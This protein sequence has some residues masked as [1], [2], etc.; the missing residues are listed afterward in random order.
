MN[1]LQAGLATA[2]TLVDAE[3]EGVR[4]AEVHVSGCQPLLFTRYNRGPERCRATITQLALHVLQK[5][6]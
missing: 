3:V 2:L 1:V 4:A 6:Q 5:V